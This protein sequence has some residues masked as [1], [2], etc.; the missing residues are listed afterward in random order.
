MSRGNRN[1]TQRNEYSLRTSENDDEPKASFKLKRGILTLVI[2][3]LGWS[4][5]SH[6][7]CIVGLWDYVGNGNTADSVLTTISIIFPSLVIA[8]LLALDMS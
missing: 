5:F 2:A 4:I 3:A 8:F 1:S 7:I 6:L